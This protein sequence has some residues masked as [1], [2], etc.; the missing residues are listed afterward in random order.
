MTEVRAER[1]EDIAG[2]RAVHVA[3]FETPAEADLVDTLRDSEAWVPGLSVVAVENDRVI[4][5]ALLSRVVLGTAEGEAPALALGP[6]AVRPEVQRQGYGSAVVRAAVARRAGLL[7]V[8]LGDPAYYRRF[9]FRPAADFGITGA[10]AGFGQAWQALPP[11][12]GTPPGEV[13][14]P[15]PWDGL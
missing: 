13:R 7:V 9:G 15:R 14:F 1:P 3:A 12:G 10:Y 11:P 4:A 2:I 8:L 6:V 5:H